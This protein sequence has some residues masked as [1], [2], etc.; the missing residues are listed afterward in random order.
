MSVLGMDFFSDV[1]IMISAAPPK[2][3]ESIM[4]PK[5]DP[6]IHATYPKVRMFQER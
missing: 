5:Y 1:S 6:P 2:S 4:M 3:F